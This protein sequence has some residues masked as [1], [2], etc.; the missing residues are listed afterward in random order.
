MAADDSTEA[1]DSSSGSAVCVLSYNNDPR[2]QALLALKS[3]WKGE[4]HDHAPASWEGAPR[5]GT[6][7]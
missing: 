3:F 5:T 4:Q 1:A 2:Q 7:G 6:C